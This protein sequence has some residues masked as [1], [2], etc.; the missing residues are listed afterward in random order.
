MDSL[1]NLERNIT[2]WI[3][4]SPQFKPGRQTMFIS[5]MFCFEDR[6]QSLKTDFGS[7]RTELYGFCSDTN[8]I[9][10][11]VQVHLV[12]LQNL[13]MDSFLHSLPMTDEMFVC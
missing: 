11:L 4:N 10:A 13:R 9:M 8:K 3:C 2:T 6:E 5:G 12:S 1:V 7:G